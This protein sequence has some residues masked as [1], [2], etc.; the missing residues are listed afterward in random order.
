MVAVP[1]ALAILPLQDETNLTRFV[2]V[3]AES[4][5]AWHKRFGNADPVELTPAKLVA[6]AM[7]SLWSTH[8]FYYSMTSGD[9][10][11]NLRHRASYTQTAPGPKLALCDG[12]SLF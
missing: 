12:N 9:A 8:S 5:P 11:T 7:H 4:K 1:R 3:L 2:E 10:N 6:E